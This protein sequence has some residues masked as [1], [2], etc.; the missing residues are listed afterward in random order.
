MNIPKFAEMYERDLRFKNYAELTIGNYVS[1]IKMFLAHFDKSEPKKINQDNIKDYLLTKININSRK[2]AHSAIKLFYLHTMKQKRKFDWIEYSRSSHTEPILLSLDEISR[3][4]K[5]TDN[6]K[7]IA[8]LATLLSTGCRRQ[9]LIDL[10]LTDFDKDNRVIYIRHGKGNKFRKVPYNDILR[11]Y[12]EPYYREHK[13]KEWLF[14]NPG[15]GQYSP[16]SVLKV[17]KQ[18][19]L[20]AGINKRAYTHLIRHVN[21]T[22]LCEQKEN[23]AVIKEITGH[24]SDKSLST[25][26]HL[27]SKIVANVETPLNRV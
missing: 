25:Y 17:I 15:G 4:F 1:Q 16:E 8:I 19:A 22:F 27:S 12:L 24:K 7:H 3:M 10:K 13:P 11:E 14:E 26:I 5:S 20:K 2:H 21:I 23:M 9:E 6:T 18:M